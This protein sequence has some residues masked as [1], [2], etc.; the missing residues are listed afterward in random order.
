[1][2]YFLVTPEDAG[3]A[4]P[5][6]G[7]GIPLYVFD[8]WLGDDL[9]RAFPVFL[10]TAGLKD[11]LEALPEPA[12]FR[13]TRIRVARSPFLRRHRPELRLPAF[14]ALEIH[15]QAGSHALGLTMDRSLVVSQAALDRLV[16]LS[17]PHAQFS[18]FVPPAEAPGTTSLPAPGREERAAEGE[19]DAVKRR[20]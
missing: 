8:T 16:Q 11:A 18:Q 12:G 5:H 14:W 6:V 19:D 1:M 9:V 17:V 7:P 13:S 3:H 2:A 20:R 4:R 15:G 10:A